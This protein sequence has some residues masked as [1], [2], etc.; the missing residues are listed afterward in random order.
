VEFRDGIWC[1]FSW[2]FFWPLEHENREQIKAI[3]PSSQTTKI[4]IDTKK[5]LTTFAQVQKDIT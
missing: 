5:C 3:L 4:M 2:P 1:L